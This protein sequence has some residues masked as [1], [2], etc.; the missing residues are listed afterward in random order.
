[1]LFLWCVLLANITYALRATTPF[2]QPIDTTELVTINNSKQY[3]RIKGNDEEKPILLYLNGGPGDSVLKQMDRMFGK[4][5][6]EFVVVLWDQRQSGQTTKIK[7]KNKVLLTQELFQQDT[8]A[9]VQYLLK[10]FKKDKLTL[11][12]HSY[13]TTLGFFMAK[14][15]PE[16]ITNFIAVNPMV[17]QTESERLTLKVLL[18]K[19]NSDRNTKAINELTQVQIPFKNSEQLYYARKWLFDFDGKRFAKKKA[20]KKQVLSWAKIWLPLFKEAS[21]DNL[22]VSAKKL[23]CPISFIIGKQDYQCN[24]ALTEK[25]YNQLEAPEKQ[26][27]PLEKAGHLIPFQNN[28]EFQTLIIQNTVS[29]E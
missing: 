6:T 9:L 23:D 12:G 4:L 25:Y 15:H 2:I 28:Q 29:K 7:T 10:K 3:I 8:Y 22:L 11:V 19:A 27:I 5:Q 20:F 21:Q 14:N 18:E 17:H 1:M 16:L 24:Y 26:L 13:G